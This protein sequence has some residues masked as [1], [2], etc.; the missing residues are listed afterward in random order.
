MIAGL[1]NLSLVDFP[2]HL[3][4]A[5]FLQGC[6]F[7]CGYC[8]NPDLVT[9]EK[10]FNYSEEK[11]LD[12]ISRRKKMIEGVVIT[13]GEPTLHKDLTG[14][15]CRIKAMGFKVKLDTNGSDPTR[16]KSLLQSGL[17]DYIALDIKTSFGRYPLITGQKDIVHTVSE[18]MRY[19]MLSMIP[20]EFRTTCVPGVVGEEDFREIGEMVN[21]AKKYCLQQFRS[22]T[23][24][25]EKFRDIQPYFKE[26][27]RK[28]RDI[29]EDFVDVVE[30]RGI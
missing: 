16:I 11:V 18:T 17:V 14:F 26:D 9:S 22:S 8:H 30:T 13:G 19:I 1:Q 3:A 20:Y 28:F 21:G 29:L 6:N 2:G 10:K 25:D 23:T 27:I 4:S 15:I 7:R 5:V 12:F 24:F